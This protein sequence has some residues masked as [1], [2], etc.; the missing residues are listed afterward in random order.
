[1][2]TQSAKQD[3]LAAIAN[4]PDNAPLDEIIYRLHVLR[5]IQEGRADIDAERVL[6]SDE[7]AH[8]IEHW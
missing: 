6:S 2:H 8:E 5:K 7:L 4:L 1:M 3:A